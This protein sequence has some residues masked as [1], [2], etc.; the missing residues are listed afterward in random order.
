MGSGYIQLIAVGSEKNIF[1]YN[2]NISFFKIYYRRHT[3]FYINNMEINGN[4]IHAFQL[5]NKITF[6]IPKNGDFL[7]KSYINLDID[8]HYFELFQ[9]N[10]ELC[11]TLNIDLLSVYDCYYINI[12]DYSINDINNINII[13]VN[14]YIPDVNNFFLSIVSSNIFSQNELLN[15]VKSQYVVELE[16]D[17]QGIFYNIDLNLLFYSFN[18]G[19]NDSNILNNSLFQY[20][21]ANIIWEKISYVQ[22]DFKQIKISLKI[23]Y[24]ANKYYKIL[25]DLILSNKFVNMINQMKINFSYIYLSLNFSNELY[26]LLLDVFYINSEIF[27]LEIINNK[28]KSSK[29]IFNEKINSKITS[30]ILNKN[31][32]T[33]IY[34][35][36]LNG[37]IQSSSILTI[38]EINTFF[39]NITNEYYNDLLIQSGNLSLNLFNLNNDKISINL[40]IKVFVSLV[41]YNNDT[42]IQNY[43]KIVNNN[44]MFNIGDILKYYMSDITSLNEKLIE[45]IMYPNI[46]IVNNKSFY[47]I[48]Y[49]KNIYE[50]FQTDIYVQPFTNNHI[51]Y[52]SNVIENY[53]FNYNTVKILNSVFNNNSNDYNYI[54]SVY[55]FLSTLSKAS[56]QKAVIN[57]NL[58]LNY[59]VN[60]NLFDT[61]IDNFESILNTSQNFDWKLF[62]NT[63]SN[64]DQTQT[65]FYQAILNNNLLLLITQSITFN[66]ENFTYISNIYDSTGKLSKTFINSNKSQLIFPCSSSM[67]VYTNNKNNLCNNKITNSHLFFNLE[68]ED[69]LNNIENNLLDLTKQQF[70]NA[71]INI[72]ENTSNLEINTYIINSKLYQII[73]VYYDTINDL[74]TEINMEYLNNYLEEIQTID[75]NIIYPFY[76]KSVFDL[77]NNIMYQQFTYVDKN[78]FN[79]SFANFTFYKYNKCNESHYETNFINEVDFEKFIFTSNSPLYRIYFYFTFIAKFT[80]DL[81]TSYIKID[82][83]INTLR[84]LTLGFVLYYFNAFNGF[85]INTSAIE[86]VISKFDF[87]KINNLMYFI[88]T[89]FLSY[90]DIDVFENNAFLNDLKNINS[91]KYLFMYNNF[92]FIKTN[93]SSYKINNVDFLNNIPNICERFNYNYDDIIIL[94]FL[95]VLYNNK[96]KFINFNSVY[97]L[98]LNFFDKSNN[99]F[100]KIITR[101]NYYIKSKSSGINEQFTTG[102]YYNNFYYTC[103]YTSF[104]IGTTFDNIDTNNT[105]CINSIVNTTSF[106]NAKYLF[107]QDYCFKEY[108]SKQYYNYLN[109]I[110]NIT[111]VFKYFQSKL[112]SIF[113]N[114][115]YLDNNYFTDYL[116]LIISYTNVNDNFLLLYKLSEFNYKNSISI[117]NFYINKFNS[118]NNT[119][120]SLSSNLNNKTYHTYSSNN[121]FI[122]IVYY[123]IYFIY[124]CMSIDIDSY[125]SL[126]NNYATNFING[127]NNDVILTFGEY[128]VN[129]YTVNIYYNCIEGLIDLFTN[130]DNNINIDFS[131][132]Y[133][134]LTN[135]TVFDKNILVFNNN[136]NNQNVYTNILTNNKEISD[137]FVNL[138]YSPMNNYLINEFQ[139]SNY[140]KLQ[141]FTIN[142]NFNILYSNM[143]INLIAKTNKIYFSI[144][145]NSDIFSKILD[146]DDISLEANYNNYKTYYYNNSILY[147]STIYKNLMNSYDK[148]QYTNTYTKRIIHY[149]FT[150]LKNFYNL[151]EY[152]YFNTMYY[153]NFNENNTNIHN[154]IINTY[155]K[156]FEQNIIDNNE[157]NILINN[158]NEY[159][160]S[161]DIYTLYSSYINGLIANSLIYEQSIN[162]IIYS[163]CTDYLISNSYDKEYTRNIIYKKTLYSIVKLY[164][165]NVN[166]NLNNLNNS[167]KIYLTNT[168]IYSNQSVFQ[169]YNY[170]NM[171]NNI[172]FTQNYWMNEIISSIDVE[173]NSFNSYYNLFIKFIDYVYFYQLD[174]LN[175]TLD[176]GT[177]VLD[178][179]KNPHN[180]NELIDLIFNYICLNESYSPNTI[181]INIIELIK[182]TTISS[183]LIIETNNLKKKNYNIFILYLDNIK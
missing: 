138:N 169:I 182:T 109:S 47:L 70:Y 26:E 6:D 55:I 60:N 1:N 78:L 14:Y 132:Y 120:I 25:F 144:Y 4:N 17:V 100:D 82:N 24:L 75:Y 175:F 83:D 37:D 46:L 85:I 116:N 156:A 118:I 124:E 63:L 80:I 136:S 86:D 141:I 179:F 148:T 9:S 33:Y 113:S 27:Q 162:R 62:F 87:N 95:E 48:L 12:N 29:N 142:K 135:S 84:D 154:H 2:P 15:Y 158:Y 174:L 170:E 21:I 137:T 98:S 153:L 168:S 43:L 79:N 181:F 111:N 16:T 59:I 88:K 112:F 173:I 57:N 127:N 133:Y 11:S 49:T 128:I 90:D 94:L 110:T 172:S 129:K 107:N 163:L 123:Y 28:I 102:T 67:Y 159:I 155:N 73:K 146:N 52:Y 126:L 54:V 20:L 50:K 71:K 35:S 180:Y 68:F 44:K 41:C 61:T 122:I 13:K 64:L 5:N 81:T 89:N 176:N 99:D 145:N 53:Y 147:L 23:T 143:I 119:N 51:S 32:D 18:I 160:N 121:N 167:N 7:G 42:T 108:N 8:E 183:K 65:F 139:K 130:S 117:I 114:K 171:Y 3:N 106:Y 69:Y 125:N 34:L 58:T 31:H 105:Q 140:F 36:V 134:Y 164:I 22:I 77:N 96:D 97:D 56:L 131:T 103:Y 10:N 104:I 76:N 66:N 178:Y 115:T 149:I 166:N 19:L 30:M 151:K 177:R 101:L 157:L 91:N 93:L 152:N 74:M 150:N 38:M 161:I 39:G 40:L 72:S 165:N 92:Y 45:F